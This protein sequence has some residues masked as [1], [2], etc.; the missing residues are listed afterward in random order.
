MDLLRLLVGPEQNICVVGDDDQSIYRWRGAE[1]ENILGFD[2]ALPDVHVVRLEQNYRCS[3][4]ILSCASALVVPA[5][6]QVVVLPAHT[7]RAP[8]PTEFPQ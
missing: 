6:A 4:H 3:G 1:V 2:R 7:A 5:A 8:M